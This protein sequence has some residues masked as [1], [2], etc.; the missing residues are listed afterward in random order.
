MM[1]AG[2]EASG[3][4]NW[5]VPLSARRISPGFRKEPMRCQI[6]DWTIFCEEWSL[7]VGRGGRVGLVTFGSLSFE[8]ESKR[9]LRTGVRAG[10]DTGVGEG[11]E[12]P[13]FIVVFSNFW[14]LRIT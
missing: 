12:I 2:K 1:S 10:H 6:Q 4:P 3:I 7:G 14:P 13:D 9:L 11:V 8:M 5:A